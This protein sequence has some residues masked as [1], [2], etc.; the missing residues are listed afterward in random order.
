MK[1]RSFVLGLVVVLGFTFS[2]VFAQK[3]V[4]VPAGGDIEGFQIA[5]ATYQ[6]SLYVSGMDYKSGMPKSYIRKFN[7]VIWSTLVEIGGFNNSISEMKEYNGELYVGGQFIEFAGIS[8]ANSLVKWNGSKWSAVGVGFDKTTFAQVNALE[9]FN[10]KLYVGGRFDSIAGIQLKN[11][12]VWNGNAW[13]AGPSCE[14]GIGQYTIVQ[15]MKTFNGNLFIGGSFEKVNSVNCKNVA[16][17][18]GTNVS[19]LSNGNGNGTNSE[20]TGFE[21]FKNE[22]Y[23]YGY[24]SMIDTAN[25]NGIAKW[26]NSQIRKLVKQPTAGVNALKALGNALYCSAPGWK[27][28]LEYFDGSNWDFAGQTK[29]SGEGTSLTV[30]NNTL[31]VFGGFISSDSSSYIFSGSA[32][33]IEAGDACKVE[34]V[35]FLDSDK[36][37]TKN[38]NEK[39]IQ[40]RIIE[41]KPVGLK[42]FT[43]SIGYFSMFLEKGNYSAKLL[44]YPYYSKTCTDSIAFSFTKKG[45]KTD[46]LFLGSYVKDTV[47]DGSVK[48]TSSNARPGFTIYYYV[49]AI[50][51]GTASQ[52][53][54]LKV[55]LDN[56]FTYSSVKGTAY[57]RYTGNTMEWDITGFKPNEIF[58]VDII[59]TVKTGTAIGTKMKTYSVIVPATTDANMSNNS[60]TAVNIVRS[61][62]DPNDKQVYPLGTGT[63]GF[64]GKNTSQS[65]RY[66][67]RFQNTGNDTAFTIAVIDTLSA[68][69]DPSTFEEVGASHPY[70]YELLSGNV[71]KFTFNNILLPDSTTNKAQSNG[72]VAFN[73]T[74]KKGLAIGTKIRNNADIYFDF[75]EPV[76][77][78]TTVTT[79]DDPASVKPI[80][81]GQNKLKIYPNPGSGVATI[82]LDRPINSN[83]I[84][85][86]QI[87][88]LFGKQIY[89]ANQT[90]DRFEID[91]TGFANSVYVIK[92]NR[93]SGE[94]ITG[95]YIK[96]N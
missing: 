93:S 17:F 46:T 31:Y 55:I 32:K 21:A 47:F 62:F 77:T 73:V 71:L 22:L 48:I 5:T 84:V 27:S 33:L 60:D 81:S 41:I 90:N 12:A 61:S 16:K 28:N 11:I 36:S 80:Y 74:P 56:N 23:L 45:E 20:V 85:T 15:G 50:N 30:Y 18:D 95:R 39:G 8:N 72:Y 26:D 70:T 65:L 35:V 69:L 6:N 34:G 9:V 44:P 79:F 76:R 2:N 57:S 58:H 40:K 19:S 68:N 52:N 91:M 96:T 83:E 13:S 4:W 88:D 87:T 53:C 42:I 67:I 89:Q 14:S 1:N 3:G 92:V 82:E 25:V 7:G 94:A 64:I 37:C 78:N 29:L 86:L 38:G 49:N 63:N 54:T 10:N 24:F 66:H 59:G 43:D 51:K 75:N